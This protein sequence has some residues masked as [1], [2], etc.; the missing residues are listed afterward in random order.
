MNQGRTKRTQ[1]CEDGRLHRDDN[2]GCDDHGSAAVPCCRLAKVARVNAMGWGH[3]KMTGHDLDAAPIDILTDDILYHLFNGTCT[4]GAPVFPPEC[5]WVPA[6]VCRRWHDVIASITRA[7]A[8]AMSSRLRDALWDAPPPERAHHHSLVRASGMALMVR[9]GLPTDAIGAWTVQNLDLMDVVAVLTT[10]AVPERVKE[11]AVMGNDVANSKRWSQYIDSMRPFVSRYGRTESCR[12]LHRHVLVAAAAGSWQDTDA[13]MGLAKAHDNCCIQVAAWHAARHE[14]I[15]VVRALLA[16]LSARSR[17]NA[18]IIDNVIEPMWLLVGRHGLFALGRFLLDIEGGRDPVLCYS[19]EEREELEKIRLGHIHDDDNWLSK[20][21]KW[22][23]VDCFDF[24]IEHNHWF[25]PKGLGAAALFSGSIEF[26]KKVA[27]WDR[28]WTWNGVDA[29]VPSFLLADVLKSG[30]M[31]GMAMRTRALPYIIN[32][33]E[34]DPFVGVED[35]YIVDIV[36]DVWDAERESVAI[37]QAAALV[38]RRWPDVWE[39][40]RASPP[41]EP[42]R[43]PPPAIQVWCEAA[44]RVDASALAQLSTGIRADIQAFLRLQDQKWRNH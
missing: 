11:A 39:R 40:Y 21:A 5:R 27:A 23:R 14:R 34:F 32:H 18:A 8:Q 9:R 16:V 44:D 10:S 26:Y 1:N 41:R 36:F 38:A 13:L 20:A 2:G 19:E 6:S 30:P 29:T 35:H 7:D 3:V 33:P 24:A 15:D 25:Y 28:V 31:W 42:R 12:R 4:D 22:N 43:Y 37:L 17:G